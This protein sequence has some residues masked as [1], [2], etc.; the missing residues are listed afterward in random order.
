MVVVVVVTVVE[1]LVVIIIAVVIYLSCSGF[2]ILRLKPARCYFLWS[3]Y[4]SMLWLEVGEISAQRCQSPPP[5][6][7]FPHPATI[8]ALYLTIGVGILCF[9]SDIWS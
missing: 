6:P 3:Y 8:Q 2:C 7:K 1:V 4:H 5:F 9:R